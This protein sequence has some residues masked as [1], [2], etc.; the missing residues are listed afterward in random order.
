[1]SQTRTPTPSMSPEEIRQEIARLKNDAERLRQ[2]V[3]GDEETTVPLGFPPVETNSLRRFMGIAQDAVNGPVAAA[4]AWAENPAGVEVAPGQYSAKHWAEIAQENAAGIADIPNHG[5]EMRGVVPAG[6]MPGQIFGVNAEG[7]E[8]EFFD[9]QEYEFTDMVRQTDI[10]TRRTTGLTLYVRLDGDDNNDGLADSPEGAFRNPQRAINE[11]RKY[12]GAGY[13][14]IIQ[15]GAGTF[16]YDMATPAIEIP[17]YTA[18]LGFSLL[19]IRGAGKTQTV[20]YNTGG[21]I[22]T[23]LYFPADFLQ[24]SD[25]TFQT[26]GVGA[27]DGCACAECCARLANIKII[28][29]MPFVWCIGISG[30]NIIRDCDFSGQFSHVIINDLPGKWTIEGT[31]AVS[32]SMSAGFLTGYGGAAKIVCNSNTTFAGSMTGKRYHF[33]E[34]CGCVTGGNGAN[35]FPGN[36]SGTLNTNGWYV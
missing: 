24:M 12:D 13:S 25:M 4:R 17:A 26:A 30:P 32:G 18:H 2:F 21:V 33:G 7:T 11:L 27:G 1:M 31:C 6:G 36:T 29:A 8:Y 19:R 22:H 23:H 28:C 9:P 15:I 35:F 34:G 16:A 20:L 5:P 10:R 3:H 14:A